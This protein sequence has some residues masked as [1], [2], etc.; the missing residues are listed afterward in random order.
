MINDRCI[1][2]HNDFRLL[3][4][5]ADSSLL[6]EELDKADV[7][8]SA[9][10]PPNVVTMYSRV[11]FED[12]AAGTTREVTVVLP[13][14][15]DPVSGKVSVLAPVGTALLG[16]AADQSIVWPFPD[17]SQRRLRVVEVVYQP[18]ADAGLA[19]DAR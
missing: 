4:A 19:Q 15:A 8:D 3:S 12:E 7:V 6:A 5:I 11:R 18:E 9:R 16:L 2:T 1:I 17:G 14:D 13:H 10:V